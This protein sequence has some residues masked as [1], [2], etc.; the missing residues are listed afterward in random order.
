MVSSQTEADRS[1]NAEEQKVY[2]RKDLQEFLDAIARECV[3]GSAG[4]IHSMFA[5]NKLL[6]LPN[7]T[8]LFDEKLKSQAKDLWLKLKSTGLQLND[9]PLLFGIQETP[10]PKGKK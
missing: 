2:T 10:Q 9:P 1:E 7:A 4:Y 6:R 5:L 3:T 8:D